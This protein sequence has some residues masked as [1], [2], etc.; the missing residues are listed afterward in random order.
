MAACYDSSSAF[1]P[2]TYRVA[3]VGRS[4]EDPDHERL[5]TRPDL[6]DTG[7]GV[8][9]DSHAQP[10]RQ[11]KSVTRLE[12]LNTVQGRQDCKFVPRPSVQ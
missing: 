6:I 1:A 2:S 10:T 12:G 9:H 8:A 7:A 3:R 11:L 4:G 5:L